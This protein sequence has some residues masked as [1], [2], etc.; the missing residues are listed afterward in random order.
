VEVKEFLEKEV[1]LRILREGRN[2]ELMIYCP[3]HGDNN[4]SLALNYRTGQ[5]H[6]FA[7]CVKGS[8]GMEGF[9]RAIDADKNIFLRFA[10]IFSTLIRYDE[11]E[12]KKDD[13]EVE[14]LPLALDN[15]YLQSRRVSNETVEKF[16]IK[17]HKGFDAIFVP[18]YMDSKLKG[19]V[20][21]NIRTQPKYL[22]SQN[23]DRDRLLFPFDSVKPSELGVIVVEGV[24]DVLNAYEKGLTNVVASLGGFISPG[25]MR[26]LGRLHR[27]VVLCPDRDESGLRIAEQ[28][29]KNL[30][31]YG[32]NISYTFAPEGYKDFGDVRN[33]GR[34]KTHSYFQL[35]AQHKDLKFISS[36]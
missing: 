25:Q 27:N 13:V 18:L 23:L 5:Y 21:R 26:L 35:A 11:P 20:R 32:F 17:Y 19:Y 34:L 16:Q 22:N 3:I 15:K 33:F 29:T 8:D 31:K 2:N 12:L 14:V 7:G 10:T 36:M 6:C 30:M 24:F 9:F 4:A 28:N 1:G